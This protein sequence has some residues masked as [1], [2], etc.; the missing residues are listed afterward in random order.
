MSLVRTKLLS[1][2]K[3]S[4][5]RL[6]KLLYEQSTIKM[7][8]DIFT[9]TYKCMYLYNESV[10]IITITC[11]T[12]PSVPNMFISFIHCSSCHNILI[13][14]YLNLDHV[15]IMVKL[16]RC[17]DDK[18]FMI[19]FGYQFLPGQDQLPKYSSSKL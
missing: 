9:I 18:L 16:G 14:L 13:K 8:N 17:E 2:E 19:G 10:F 11:C 7:M 1:K 12:H 5:C 3:K 4:G 15:K 6:T